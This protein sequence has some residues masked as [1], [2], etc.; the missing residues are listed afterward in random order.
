MQSQKQQND[1]CSFPRQTY[2]PRDSQESSPKPQFKSIS[3]S[4]L[5]LLSQ[6]LGMWA[7]E[8][9]LDVRSHIY[10]WVLDNTKALAIQ[11]FVGKVMP[12]VCNMLSSFVM[13]FLP[14]GKCFFFFFNFM[15][16][17][18]IC[19]DFGTQEN[20]VCH[21]LYCFPMYLTWSNGTR[22][23]DLSFLNVECQASFFTLLYHSHQEV[24]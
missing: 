13:V 11:T 5:S 8:A 22:C 12:V 19:S 7:C 20:K 17:V 1:L 2:C 15:A 4:V 16:S 10:T 6:F 23:Y 14:K 9:N 24:L 18:T 3:S 21:C